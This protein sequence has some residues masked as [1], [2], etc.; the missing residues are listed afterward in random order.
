MQL[1]LSAGMP[2]SG[3][4]WL[5]N[6]VRLLL[7]HRDGSAC[8]QCGWIDDLAEAPPAARRLVK[9]H[10]F[11][12]TLVARAS[13]VVWSYRD[14]RDA[15][16]SRFRMFGTPPTLALADQLVDQHARWSA[17]AQH[18]LRYES[19]LRD[20]TAA[21]AALAAAIGVPVQPAD[22]D[23]VR[24]QLDQARNDGHVGDVPYDA[25]TLMHKGHIT[26]GRPRSWRSGLSANLAREITERHA[27]WLQAH[28]YDVT[29]EGT[30]P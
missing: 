16:A 28:G 3:S 30:A 26:D 9:L 23:A 7:A 24:Q 12:P 27:D 2:R 20:P 1:V 19:M 25:T 15:V 8:W 29:S 14:L 21:L 22:L 18:T 11:E 17:V 4:T 5:Y 10:L 13:Y 6:A